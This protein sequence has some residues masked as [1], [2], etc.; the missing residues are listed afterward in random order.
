MG[1]LPLVNTGK[2][3]VSLPH[4]SYGGVWMDSRGDL[5]K[6]RLINS[7]IDIVNS[8]KCDPGFYRV[9]IEKIVYQ[10][11]RLGLKYFIR[12]FD[13]QKD[14]S[15]I[16]S[17]KVT[18]IFNIDTDQEKTFAGLGSNLRRKINKSL[19]SNVEIK[20]G[21][22]ELLH[23]FYQVYTKNIYHLKSLNYSKRFFED[24]CH[25]YQFGNLRF[26]VSY[27]N[28]KPAGSALLASYG[29][30]YEN[31]YFAT[32]HQY[33]KYYVSDGLHWKMIQYATEDKLDSKDGNKV[34]SFGRSTI[35]SPVHQYKNHWPVTSIPLFVYSNINDVRQNNLLKNTWG[36]LP[37]FI[38]KPLGTRLIKHI[39]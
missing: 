33:R 20:S 35:D 22:V 39:Y 25:S 4:F 16:K 31:L 14:E 8:E 15:F 28:G 13:D 38:T 34:Y 17:E 2:A 12:A 19:K 29:G 32:L 26:F 18:T 5:S 10:Q 37:G 36:L 21:G 7:V 9:N 11:S 30:F 23:D 6:N 27:F 24:L 3:W 1:V